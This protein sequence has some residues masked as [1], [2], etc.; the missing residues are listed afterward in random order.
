M[1]GLAQAVHLAAAS[2]LG[3][4]AAFA[5]DLR[6]TALA[7]PPPGAAAALDNLTLALTQVDGSIDVVFAARP[8][9]A[10]LDD[11]LSLVILQTGFQVRF[12]VF[13]DTAGRGEIFT[14]IY[15]FREAHG[16]DWHVCRGWWAWPR[17]D[18]YAAQLRDRFGGSIVFID[19][20][21]SSDADDNPEADYL[22]ARH[23]DPAFAAVFGLEPFRVEEP[24]AYLKIGEMFWHQVTQIDAWPGLERLL[25]RGGWVDG[26]GDRS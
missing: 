4:A 18:G 2:L 19:N 22:T 11:F 15:D 14:Q 5:E 8:D 20:G 6:A 17:A 1:M 7:F 26:Y 25:D 12:S 24:E 3:G 10:A 16:L 23:L 9:L 13:P 21:A